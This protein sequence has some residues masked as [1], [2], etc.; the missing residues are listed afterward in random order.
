M[1][2]NYP[3]GLDGFTNPGPTD[4]LSSAGVSHSDQH[5]DANDAIEAL[6]AKVGVDGSAVTTSHDYKIAALETSVSV[7]ESEIDTLQSDVTTLEGRV[8][9]I[10]EVQTNEQTGTAYTLVLADSGKVVETNNASA[11]TL[12]VP[13][14]SS[15]AFP[16]GVQITVLQTGA[17]QT[18]LVAGSGVTVNSADGNLKVTGQWSAATLLKRATDTWVAIGDLSA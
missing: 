15:V 2:T 12:T 11:N 8:D 16:V 10:V 17:G 3:T 9:N 18:T 4:L 5:G 1:A 13:P 6:Q 14:N 7:A